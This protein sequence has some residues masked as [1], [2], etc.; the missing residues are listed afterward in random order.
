MRKTT[1]ATAYILNPNS[2]IALFLIA[3]VFLT[4]GVMVRNAVMDA[5][6]VAGTALAVLAVILEAKFRI[7]TN[8]YF[9]VFH[10]IQ[11]GPDSRSQIL[12]RLCAAAATSI[13]LATIVSIV[14]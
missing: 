4:S 10:I 9:W 14:L 13:L 12:S 7:T 6:L 5:G 11:W 3:L 2:Y 1:S 8:T